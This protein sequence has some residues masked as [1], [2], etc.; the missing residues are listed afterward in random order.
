MDR[1]KDVSQPAK[2]DIQYND[3][4]AEVAKRF[5]VKDAEVI[6]ISQSKASRVL[7]KK[8]KDLDVLVE[9]ASHVGI[10]VDLIFK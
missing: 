1:F 4:L 7:N 2:L 10:D 6:K 9:M 3:L 5:R 8:Q